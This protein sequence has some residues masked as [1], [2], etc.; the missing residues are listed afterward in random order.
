MS[1][2]AA[3]YLVGWRSTSS[4]HFDCKA[5]LS[6]LPRK[7]LLDDS[8]GDLSIALIPFHDLKVDGKSI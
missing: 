2:Q 8:E 4:T 1:V 3:L 6:Q 7:R 5:E